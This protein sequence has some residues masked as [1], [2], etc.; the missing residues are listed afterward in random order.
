ME[1]WEILLIVLACI[2]FVGLVLV[3]VLWPSRD[4]FT[5]QKVDALVYRSDDAFY[6]E[7]SNV[8]PYEYME[9]KYKDYEY[10]KG[11]YKDGEVTLG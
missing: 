2:S 11:R 8:S 5:D 3:L 6:D 10:V 9:E 7:K 1:W 4:R